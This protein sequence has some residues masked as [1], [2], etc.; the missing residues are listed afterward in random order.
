[1]RHVAI[2]SL[3]NVMLYVVTITVRRINR[4]RTISPLVGTAA[5]VTLPEIYLDRAQRLPEY[6]REVKLPFFL[7][8]RLVAGQ[9]LAMG[10]RQHLRAG[11]P[12]I[13]LE[14]RSFALPR[15]R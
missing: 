9:R 11:M 15:R 2:L 13:D 3:Q 8:L 12:K 7:W 10:H 1:M 5:S 14:C 4:A 6:G